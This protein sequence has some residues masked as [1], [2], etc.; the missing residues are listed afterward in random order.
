[1]KQEGVVNRTYHFNV[2]DLVSHSVYNE[3]DEKMIYHF[4]L[5][6]LVPYSVH[7]VCVTAANQEGNGTKFCLQDVYTE[8]TGKSKYKLSSRCICYGGR[9][10]EFEVYK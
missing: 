6:D 7:N 3:D 9:D 8:E 2:G 5:T 10:D 4:N 1:M